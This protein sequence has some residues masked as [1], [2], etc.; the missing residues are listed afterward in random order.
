[1]EIKDRILLGHIVM[2]NS[3]L[4]NLETK[5]EI[6][7][8]LPWR[9]IHKGACGEASCKR[10]FADGINFRIAGRI[11]FTHWV[12]RGTMKSGTIKGWKPNCFDVLNLVVRTDEDNSMASPMA[13]VAEARPWTR[14]WTAPDRN[15]EKM[16][17]KIL[18]YDQTENG[19]DKKHNNNNIE[20]MNLEYEIGI[21]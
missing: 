8:T 21:L 16:S 4:K 7:G 14:P 1:V 5:L 9:L 6:F 18:S 17:S 10:S 2:F 13:T 11:T 12:R 20:Y 19:M 15:P 3:F